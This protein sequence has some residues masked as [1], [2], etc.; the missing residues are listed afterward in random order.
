[1]IL[2]IFCSLA[3]SL[4][5]CVCVQAAAETAVAERR[6]ALE[7]MRDK[8]SAPSP[9]IPHSRSCLCVAVCACVWFDVLVVVTT[10]AC[11]GEAGGG[12]GACFE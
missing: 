10:V 12:E 4:A 5:R 1:M 2:L 11:A 3:R 7:T 8:A 9:L 6:K